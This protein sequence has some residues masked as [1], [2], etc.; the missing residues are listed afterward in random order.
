MMVP[1]PQPPG[2]PG[3]K[4]HPRPATRRTLS[5]VALID[6]ITASIADA[7]RQHDPVRLSS[8]RMLKAA[9]SES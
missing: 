5:P 9:L 7:M 2:A 4:P 8:L 3:Q 6:E 1:T